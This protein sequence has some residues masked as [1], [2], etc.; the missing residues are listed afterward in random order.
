MQGYSLRVYAHRTTEGLGCRRTPPH[1]TCVLSSHSSACRLC[2]RV[3]VALL[4]LPP[5]LS[6]CRCTPP[7]ATCVAWSSSHSSACHL[8]C[9]LVVA[10][11]RMPPV[12]LT[13]LTQMCQKS[14]SGLDDGG[15]ED[16]CGLQLLSRSGATARHRLSVLRRSE[17]PMQIIKLCKRTCQ[18]IVGSLFDEMQ[19]ATPSTHHA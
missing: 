19:S 4:R 9:L 7:H 11:L 1:A 16:D 8:C 18:H 13:H 10:L 12:F 15:N 6:C 17:P 2:C 3:V 5:V 14:Q